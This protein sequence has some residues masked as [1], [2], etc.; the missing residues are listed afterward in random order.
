M[1]AFTQT[2]WF[3][4]GLRHAVTDVNIFTDTLVCIP[5][6]AVPDQTVDEFI[7]DLTEINAPSS[8]A[9]IT[10]RAWTEDTTNLELELDCDDPTMPTL[11]TSNTYIGYV[12]AADLGADSASPVLMFVDTDNVTCNGGNVKV[13]LPAEGLFKL[14]CY[15]T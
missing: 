12:I 6:S 13:T 11:P 8:R 2:D 1:S 3:L 14:H 7:D 5:V 10:N 15:T 9:T 4:K